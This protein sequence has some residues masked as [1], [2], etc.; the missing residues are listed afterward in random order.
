[1]EAT[2]AYSE[3]QTRAIHNK[4]TPP[5]A[6]AGKEDSGIMVMCC[7]DTGATQTVIHED[8]ARQAGLYINPPGTKI[9]TATGSG[10]N[11]VGEADICLQYKHHK[12]YTTALISSDVRFTILVAWHDLQPLYVIS[13]PFPTCLCA[14]QHQPVQDDITN[15]YPE[16]FCDSLTEV[17]M[18]VPDML[19]YLS[20]N[21][22]PYRI[23]T[24]H[25][26]PLRFQEEGDETILKLMG[27]GVIVRVDGPETL[28][29][30]SVL[31]A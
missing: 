31:C 14:T 27:A 6:P 2:A 11:V 26:V 30:S 12:L 17:P 4:L 25:Q 20:E 9:S 7:L 3:A 15:M 19:I 24:P 1:M 8:I 28:V 22:V 29:C 13:E 23:S 16:V 18:N 10:M 21:A 5:L